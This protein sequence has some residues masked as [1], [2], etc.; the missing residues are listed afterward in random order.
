MLI[1]A[2]GRVAV[3]AMPSSW[4]HPDTFLLP[5]AVVPSPTPGSPS[6]FFLCSAASCEFRAA[7]VPLG[8]A[9]GLAALTQG[10]VAEVC[11]CCGGHHG[12]VFVS[13]C[14]RRGVG[15]LFQLLATWNMCAV[16][17]G[18]QVLVWMCVSTFLG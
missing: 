18:S 3:A 12:V 14:V 2:D 6:V 16:N 15:G 5:F 9:C 4:C 10:G 7:G 11:P 8:R 13:L 17:I 1:T